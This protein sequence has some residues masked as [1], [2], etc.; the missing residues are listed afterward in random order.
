MFSGVLLEVEVPAALPEDRLLAVRVG[1]DVSGAVGSG[2]VGS[3]AV[4]SG[5]THAAE[6][7]DALPEVE[8]MVEVPRDAAP[9]STLYV[10]YTPAAATGAAPSVTLD[11][12]ASAD[13]S[14]D[15]SAVAAR[16]SCVDSRIV[17]VRAS[18][19]RASDIAPE[20]TSLR[21]SNANA[22]PSG[23]ATEETDESTEASASAAARRHAPPAP[24]APETSGQR[25]RRWRRL[26]E[27]ATP[28]EHGVTARVLFAAGR[29]S[30]GAQAPRP[31]T[32]SDAQPHA[33]PQPQPQPQRQAQAQAQAQASQASP[34]PQPQAQAQA[35]ASP[36][37]SFCRVCLGSGLTSSLLTDGLARSLL[38]QL[39][40]TEA[41]PIVADETDEAA[42][43][44]AA[45]QA[46][47]AAAAATAAVAAEATEERLCGV[48]F[49]DGE[50][51]ISTECRGRPQHYYCADC[52][53]GS[54]QSMLEQGQFPLRCPGC[55]S[56]STA[57]AT[58]RQVEA[59]IGGRVGEE[60]LSFFALRGVLPRPL[61]F[62][63]LNGS[64][65][66]GGVAMAVESFACPVDCG[67][68]LLRGHPSYRARAAHAGEVSVGEIF[69]RRGP[70]GLRLGRCECGA[71]VCLA[72]ETRVP[73]AEAT[74]HLCKQGGEALDP[75]SKALLARI[76]KACPGCG[77]LCQK[78]EGC[79]LM[80]CGTSAHGKV[81]D[82]LRN[83]GCAYVWQWDTCEAVIDNHGYVGL[84]G[85]IHIG[86]GP[87]TERQVLLKYS[88]QLSD[89]ERRRAREARARGGY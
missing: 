52:L 11:E 62:R 38:A 6:A 34:Q 24:A 18:G 16:Y 28:G 68:F 14:A 59:D 87:D 43:E 78:T 27:R 54:L 73:D 13:A 15:A 42:G 30:A 89:A 85:K 46:A 64:R 76:A 51:R 26:L 44:A 8:L 83:G 7:H 19:W 80:F 69:S 37:A 77:T 1:A 40:P 31:S 84:D 4:L 23:S 33:Q 9:G 50:F 75:A 2:A 58:G 74:A 57:V 21:R 48:C 82:A 60:A 63:L 39:E 55:R 12:A 61:L 47:A 71:L 86:E 65:G 41:K 67:H 22:A 70:A 35:Q 53:R 66:A 36:P 5:A 17:E 88:E 79:Q 45:A 72:C 56:D 20:P 3:G 81:A 10:R 49:G 29:S 25:R 32:Q